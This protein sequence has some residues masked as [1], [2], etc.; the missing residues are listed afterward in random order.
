MTQ[1]EASHSRTA[2]AARLFAHAR[3]GGGKKHNLGE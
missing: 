3:P 1:S 2:Q